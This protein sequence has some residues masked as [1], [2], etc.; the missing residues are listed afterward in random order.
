M[1]SRNVFGVLKRLATQRS[2]EP[3]QFLG[4]AEKSGQYFVVALDLGTAKAFRLR[5]AWPGFLSQRRP[6]YEC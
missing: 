3:A 2:G 5:L 4:V 1:S 6:P